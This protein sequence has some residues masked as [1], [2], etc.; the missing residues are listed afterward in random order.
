[1][2][3]PTGDCVISV[4]RTALIEMLLASLEEAIHGPADAKFTWFNSNE[5]D[6]GLAGVM[7]RLAAE[8][9]SR[10]PTPGG[11]TIA[12]H[13]AHAT[14]HLVASAAWLKGDRSAADWEASWEPATV[15]GGGWQRLRESL[16]QAHTAVADEIRRKQDWDKLDLGGAVGAIAHAAYH[17][18][19][20]RQIVRVVERDD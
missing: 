15:D 6:S 13:V 17:L 2:S 20:I 7:K 9:A 11:R 14:F 1:M 16:E 19:A 8:Q 18:G 12:A 4:D 10:P 3:A 5:P